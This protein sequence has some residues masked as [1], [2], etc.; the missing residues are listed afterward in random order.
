M[1]WPDDLKA[2]IHKARLVLEAADSYVG[3]DRLDE[4]EEKLAEAERLI[5]EF[6]QG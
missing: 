1:Q 4:A 2:A 6:R 5:R 3:E